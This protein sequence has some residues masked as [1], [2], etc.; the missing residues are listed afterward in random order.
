MTRFAKWVP[1]VKRASLLLAVFLLSASAFSALRYTCPCPSLCVS[2][3]DPADLEVDNACVD[4]CIDKTHT[5][6]YCTHV[7]TY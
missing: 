2:Y 1:T 5:L 3:T 6:N 7:C 4:F